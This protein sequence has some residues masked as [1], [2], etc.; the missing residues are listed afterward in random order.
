MNWV[1]QRSG[2]VDMAQNGSSDE[3][4][5]MQRAMMI[6]VIKMIDLL[7]AHVIID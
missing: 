2:I 3:R 1:V 6:N 5:K 4:D 7:I